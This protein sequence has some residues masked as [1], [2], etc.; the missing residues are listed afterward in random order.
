MRRPT[1]PGMLPEVVVYNAVSLDGRVT[2]FADEPGRYYRLGFRWASDAILMGSETALAFGPSETPAE[3]EQERPPLPG[4]PVVPGFEALVTE[5]RPLL[6]VPDSAGR[7]HTWR[8][9]RS[10]PWYRAAVSLVSA[11]TPDDH[12][13]YLRRRGVDVV[14]AGDDRVDLRAALSELAERW[15]VRRVR[16]DGGGRLAGALF[17]AGLVTELAVLL[18]PTVVGDAGARSLVEGLT[19]GAAT[20][21]ALIELERLDD[22]ALWLRYRV[23]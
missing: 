3:R 4:E 16:T 2:G 13:S 12:L 8:H 1:L 11:R 23:G 17:D 21:L 22:G 6:V 20:P 9:A 5:P 19:S 7:V 14:A 10:Q 18:V 15:G